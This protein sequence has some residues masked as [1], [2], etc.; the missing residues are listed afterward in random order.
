MEDRLLHGDT[1]IEAMKIYVFGNGNICFAEFKD[2]YESEIVKCAS[3]D[4]ASFLLCEFKGVDTLAMELL[5]CLSANVSIFHVGERPRYF[6]DKYKTKASQW[7]LVGGFGSDEER[8]GEAIKQCTH[9]LAFDYNSDKKRT[10]GTQKNIALCEAL[11]K[12]RLGDPGAPPR[13]H[14]PL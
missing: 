10:S 6:P 5:K 7:A 1:E 4:S 12:I 14:L 3:N 11:G 8:D 13:A 2:K 9:F